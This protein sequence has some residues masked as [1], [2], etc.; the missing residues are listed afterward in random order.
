VAG[1]TV[2]RKRRYASGA[3]R[4]KAYRRRKRLAK[5]L[6]DCSSR[7]DDYATPQAFFDELNREF[8]FTLD[9]CANGE[10]AKCARYFSRE[11]DGLKHPWRG[12][13]WCNPPYGKEI[14]YWVQKAFEASL[15]G[16]TCVCL[17]PARLGTQWWVR[18]VKRASE[19]REPPTR[20]RFGQSKSTA[21]F[22]SVVVIFRPPGS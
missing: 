12:V 7:S 3:E 9:V 8:H 22:F 1:K 2:G 11:Q 14:P 21:Q 20:L 17:V 15:Y 4:S 19:I 13:I 10:N 16:A 6:I 5:A 18:Y